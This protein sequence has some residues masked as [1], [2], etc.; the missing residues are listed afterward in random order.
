[1]TAGVQSDAAGL[2]VMSNAKLHYSSN[3]AEPYNKEQAPGKMADVNEVTELNALLAMKGGEGDASYAKNSQTQAQG[4]R[5][6]QPVLQAAIHR[7]D[8]P[9]RTGVVRIADLGCSSGPNSIP[10]AVQRQDSPAYNDGF[11]WIHGG[12]PAAAKAYAEQSRRDLVTFLRARAEEMVSGG[13]MFLL[14]KGRKDSDPTVQYDPDGVTMFGTQMEGVFNELISEG[15]L[16][17]SVRDSFNIP[18][19]YPTVDEMREAI[20]E[21]GSFLVDRLELLNDVPAN[22]FTKQELEANPT[23]CGRKLA[24]ICRSLL[25]VLVDTHMGVNVADQF[26]HRLELRAI[27][28]SRAESLRPRAAYSNVNLAVLIKK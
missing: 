4:F 6:V 24:K 5:F 21:S 19:Y 27:T 17:A 11:V 3:A 22:P 8:L 14:L 10:E 28:R 26:F 16:D 13:L 25:G 2:D 12:K 7:M 18:M 9:T 15:L 1:M 20:D 23:D